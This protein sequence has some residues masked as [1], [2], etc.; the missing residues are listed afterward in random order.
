MAKIK[1]VLFLDIDEVFTTSGSRK[2]RELVDEA[3]FALNKVKK[4]GYSPFVFITA[5]SGRW[6]LSDF[7]PLL[8]K[9]NLLGDSVFFCE[10]GA[11]EIKNK[12]FILT[13]VVKQ[14]TS[15]KKLIR[16]NI[17]KEIEKQRIEA[18]DVTEKLGKVVQVRF[19]PKEKTK[20]NINKV[21]KLC[22]KVL[23]KLKKQ[24]RISHK[25]KTHPT[26]SGVNIF[27]DSISKKNAAKIVARRLKKEGYKV[28]GIA[29]GDKPK[30]LKMAEAADKFK[31]KRVLGYKEFL[32]Y[33]Q[34]EILE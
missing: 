28:Q 24:E 31:P 6:V 15:K 2:E 14:F 5:R 7:I 26:N 30:D 11:Y 21:A 3:V 16:K 1:K 12:K 20:E 33:L 17:Q 22:K 32:K 27:P 19:E 29:I 34:N 9:Y 18:E 8:K 25:I 4:Q 23:N 13:G 10:D